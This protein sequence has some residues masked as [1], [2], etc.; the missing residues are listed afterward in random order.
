MFRIKVFNHELVWFRRRLI[1]LDRI[2]SAF[3][4][5]LIINECKIDVVLDVGANTG[6]YG[7]A[8]RRDG[9]KGII[10]SFEPIK[11]VYD[12]LKMTS[13]DDPNWFCHRL[14]F[15]EIA[16]EKLIN[17]MEFSTDFSSFQKP[18]EYGKNRFH[19][20]VE[21]SR[22]EKVQ[23]DTVDNFLKDKKYNGKRVCLKMDTQGYDLEVFKGCS[24]S[25]EKIY[26]IQ[27]ELAIKK[28][29]ENMPNYIDSLQVYQ[30]KGYELAGMYAVSRENNME[31]IEMDAIFI[32]S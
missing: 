5:P 26:V 11:Q 20:Y 13:A 17:V 21:P 28:I 30:N 23:V 1:R 32:K 9:Y 8:L 12:L 25:L 6:Q 14:A 27:S 18:S 4:I 19:Q 16:E 31:L 10:H 24:N 22:Q 15:G 2:I 7:K 3:S 29:Y